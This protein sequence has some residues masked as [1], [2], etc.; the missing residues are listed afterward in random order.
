MLLIVK[1]G[2]KY[3]VMSVDSKKQERYN[4]TLKNYNNFAS[5]FTDPAKKRQRIIQKIV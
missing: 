4:E 1:A 2:Y 5:L 3:S